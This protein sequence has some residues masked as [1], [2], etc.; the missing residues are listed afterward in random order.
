MLAPNTLSTPQSRFRSTHG[1]DPVVEGLSI[2]FICLF[3]LTSACACKKSSVNS[4]D[5]WL[6]SFIGS[7]GL[8]IDEY[9]F[10]RPSIIACCDQLSGIIITIWESTASDLQYHVFF[11]DIGL[12]R[13]VA[14]PT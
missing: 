12:A 13:P 14:T 3:R 6:I 2:A 8:M 1:N 11:L 4:P 9:Q 5:R 7:F 10:L